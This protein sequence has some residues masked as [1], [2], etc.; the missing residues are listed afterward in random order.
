MH[1][2]FRVIF[3]FMLSCLLATAI[4]SNPLKKLARKLEKG[5]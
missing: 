3:V 2:G 4:S 1:R 5:L